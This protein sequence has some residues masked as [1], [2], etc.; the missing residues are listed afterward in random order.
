[1][2]EENSPIHKPIST[3]TLADSSS[4]IEQ[5]VHTVP[6]PHGGKLQVGNPGNKGG[7]DK[8]SVYKAWLKSLLHSQ[9]HREE[10]QRVMED[11]DHRMFMAAAQHAAHYAEGKPVEH[12]Q[13]EDITIR[14][15]TE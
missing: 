13:V 14:V 5:V 15:T 8:P 3:N 4:V 9:K 12:I 7:G 11:G 6:Q 2:I 10:Y 1:M